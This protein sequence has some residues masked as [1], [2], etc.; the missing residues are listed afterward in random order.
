MS[1]FLHCHQGTGY[2]RRRWEYH[3]YH[4]NNHL[5]HHHHLLLTTT[6][7]PH[8][9]PIMHLVQ[10]HPS[11]S[12]LPNNNNHHNIPHWHLDT[13]LEVPPL[14]MMATMV[15]VWVVQRTTIIG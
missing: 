7:P 11:Q 10:A 9:L 2:Q 15:V 13:L 8:L 1:R 6:L 3:H 5:Y 12:L 4:N 14:V